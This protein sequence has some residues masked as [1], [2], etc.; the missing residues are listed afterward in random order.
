M[1][2]KSVL[3]PVAVDSITTRLPEGVETMRA[4]TPALAELISVTA[5]SS[6]ALAR[7]VI[8]LGETAGSL[9][10]VAPEPTVPLVVPKC[11]AMVDAAPGFTTVV[12][13]A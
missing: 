8:F 4:F 2:R 6:V 13:D 9:T 11:M 7:I 3:L 10:K 12:L 5:C 1:A